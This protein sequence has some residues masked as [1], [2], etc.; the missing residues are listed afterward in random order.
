MGRTLYILGNGFDLHHHIPSSFKAFGGYLL[1]HDPGT[2]EVVERYF[3]MDTQFWGEFEE[4]LAHFDSDSLIEDASDFLVSYGAEDWSDAYHHDYQ[5][6]I[7]S[8]VDAVS[9][10]L[11]LRFAEWIRQLPIPAPADIAGISVSIDPSAAFLNFNYTPSLQC[12]YSVPDRNILHIHGSASDPTESLVLGHGWKPASVIDPYRHE[13]DR[14]DADTRV[15]EGQQ[16]VE[17]YFK[18]TFKPTSQIVA[19]H[20][21]FFTGLSDVDTI[22]VMGHSISEVDQPYFREIIANINSSA[23]RWKI[24]YRNDLDGLR[25]RMTALGLASSL[26]EYSLI[27]N[28]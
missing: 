27:E 6:E 4:R 21:S 25:N 8:A 14:E 16:L 26:V 2:Y 22:L 7:R 15:I 12:L 20:A 3:D 5:H 9:K 18:G 13:Q 23:V 10:T 17:D 11:R 28:F 1:K 24:S 19:K